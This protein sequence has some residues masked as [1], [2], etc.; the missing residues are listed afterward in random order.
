MEKENNLTSNEVK[1]RCFIITPIGAPESS[2]RRKADGVI[3]SVLEPQLRKMGFEVFIPQRMPNPGSINKSVLEH[4][5]S[6]ELVIA[7]LTSLNANV[8]YELATRHAT[9]K[10]VV[11]IAELDTKLPFDIASERTLFYKDDMLGVDLLKKEIP[12]FIE[13]A[14]EESDI[15]NPIYDAKKDFAM[16]DIITND[17]DQYLVDKIDSLSDI[18]N[19]LKISSRYKSQ[20]PKQTYKKSRRDKSTTYYICTEQEAETFCLKERGYKLINSYNYSLNGK[21]SE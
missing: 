6:D 13:S 10:P 17:K 2:I 4:I 9:G 16:K 8:M 7:N 12:L 3:N 18:I 1:K 21:P 5:L 19:E 20:A 14:L 15:S 11:C